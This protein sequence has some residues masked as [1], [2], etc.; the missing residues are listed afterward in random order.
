MLGSPSGRPSCPGRW[1][2]GRYPLSPGQR[3]RRQFDHD[4]WK[5]PRHPPDRLRRND[6]LPP[7][8]G[9]EGNADDS[10]AARDRTGRPQRRRP[11][12]VVRLGT[13]W[14]AVPS[15]GARK[16]TGRDPISLATGVQK[17]E[18]LL[19]DLAEL[20]LEATS[21][22]VIHARRQVRAETPRAPCSVTRT[23]RGAGAGGPE[24]T[25]PDISFVGGTTMLNHSTTARTL[26]TRRRNSRDGA[27]VTH[28][29]RAEP[30]CR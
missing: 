10:K 16:E 2:P 9:L 26:I 20:G 15:F 1:T 22:R 8:G 27:F 30:I 28:T 3:G 12:R 19:R 6:D 29:T 23:R 17:V 5:R 11:E 24:G 18:G 21:I 13:A 14:I 4:E 25:P 7:R